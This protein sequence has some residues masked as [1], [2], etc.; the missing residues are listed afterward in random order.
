MYYR[1]KGLKVILHLEN[2]KG[3]QVWSNQQQTEKISPK[4]SQNLLS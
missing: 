1:T 3:G 2:R 4:G